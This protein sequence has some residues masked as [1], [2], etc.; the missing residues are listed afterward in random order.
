LQPAI[1]GDIQEADSCVRIVT[2]PEETL[3]KPGIKSRIWTL[4]VAKSLSPWMAICNTIP[5]RFLF[6]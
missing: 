2:L 3:G 4:P 5:P 6:R 1:L